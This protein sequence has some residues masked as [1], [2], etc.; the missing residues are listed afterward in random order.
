MIFK[1]KNITPRAR[2][3]TL[4]ETLL[5]VLL[6]TTAIAGPLTIA[7]RALNSALLVKDQISA[8][9]LA[10][11][12]MEYIR[13]IRD[14]A[15]LEAGSGA[16]G[17]CPAGVWMASLSSCIGAVGCAVDSV[18]N[19]VYSAAAAPYNGPLMYDT[20]NHWFTYSSL[21]AVE[22]PPR[23]IRRVTITPSGA[24]EAVVT[25]TVSWTNIAGITHPAVTIRENLMRWQ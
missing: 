3:F 7:S 5:A 17:G 6:L 9:Y 24:D 13:F 16:E 2:G 1:L 21:T 15:C 25:V 19:A 12:A 10:Q 11:D 4:I 23:F 8:F 14:S 18:Q 22:A 20:A